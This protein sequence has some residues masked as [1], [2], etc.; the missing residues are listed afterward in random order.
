LK[1]NK[2]KIREVGWPNWRWHI[3]AVAETQ[4]DQYAWGITVVEDLER[5]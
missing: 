5:T 1:T 3:S 4:E 2:L